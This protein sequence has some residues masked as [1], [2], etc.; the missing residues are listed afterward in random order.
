MNKKL[1]ERLNISESRRLLPL[2]FTELNKNDI[3]YHRWH[4][5]TVYCELLH[6]VSVIDECCRRFEETFKRRDYYMVRLT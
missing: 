4:I 3:D 2:G 5:E 6:E 1:A